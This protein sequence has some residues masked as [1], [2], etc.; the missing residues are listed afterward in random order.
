MQLKK[1]RLRQLYRLSKLEKL[2]VCP[3]SRLNNNEILIAVSDHNP[4]E[5]I[6]GLGDRGGAG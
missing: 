6:I 2:D 5:M 1:R 4:F 3:A